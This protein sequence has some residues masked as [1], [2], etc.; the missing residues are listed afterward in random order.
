MG[1]RKRRILIVQKYAGRPDSTRG[2]SVAGPSKRGERHGGAVVALK[3]FRGGRPAKGDSK[4][5]EVLRD[6]RRRMRSLWSKSS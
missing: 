6:L 2:L 1:G 5:L 4:G 3:N